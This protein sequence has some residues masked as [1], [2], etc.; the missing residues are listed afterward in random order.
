MTRLK[1]VFFDLDD[2]LLWDA[3]AVQEAFD[4]TCQRA[5]QQYEISPKELERA[6]RHAARQLYESYET[7]AF[8]QMIGIN[9]FEGLWGKFNSDHLKG[10]KRLNEIVPHYRR[11]AWTAGLK[12]LGIDD[13]E[14]GQELGE[15]FPKER[16]K[17]SIVYSDTYEVLKELKKSFRLLLLTNGSPDLQRE[18]LA[19]EPDLP[20][21]FEQI[22]ISGEFGRGKPDPAIFHHALNLMNLKQDEAIMVGDNLLTDILG[23]HQAGI[24]NVWINRENKEPRPDIVVPD[25]EISS[26]SELLPLIHSLS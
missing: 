13:P 26:L 9:P 3:K 12:E 15:Q 2:T 21:Y 20:P 10:F 1:A 17:R 24:K 4:A 8:T 23:S 16:R 22:V 18:K 11:E 5:A 14:L 6:V 7:F 25:Y 19:M